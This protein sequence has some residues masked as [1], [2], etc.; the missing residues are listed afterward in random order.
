[1]KEEAKQKLLK[2]LE[3]CNGNFIDAETAMVQVL[4]LHDKSC[5]AHMIE[6]LISI[7]VL[8]RMDA[9][10]IGQEEI[11]IA[12]ANNIAGKAIKTLKI[13]N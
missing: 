3:E 10:S 8:T 2:I 9:S 7:E 13:N 5:N 6:S 11:N 12:K 4:D 1:M